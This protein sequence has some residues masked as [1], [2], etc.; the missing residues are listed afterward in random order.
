[1]KP[2]KEIG[3]DNN[4][5]DK[6]PWRENIK[7]VIP[8]LSQ[9]GYYNPNHPKLSS[10]TNE[11]I[12]DI[13]A[14]NLDEKI[15]WMQVAIYLDKKNSHLVGVSFFDVRPYFLVRSYWVMEPEDT[16]KAIELTKNYAPILWDINPTE[17]TIMFETVVYYPFSGE[18]LENALSTMLFFEDSFLKDLH[19]N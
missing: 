4:L 19:K 15:D 1:M 9:K 18:A 12:F 14:D 6:Y 3:I 16:T 5:Q 13:L 17:N 8:Y 2:K 11:K 7:L 10:N